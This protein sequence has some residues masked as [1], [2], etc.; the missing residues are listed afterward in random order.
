MIYRSRLKRL[1]SLNRKV[2]ID[3][4]EYMESDIMV[5]KIRI[6]IVTKVMVTKKCHPCHHNNYWYWMGNKL[7][8]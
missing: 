5:T 4:C 1:H 2:D 7:T 6:S 3:F 8:P